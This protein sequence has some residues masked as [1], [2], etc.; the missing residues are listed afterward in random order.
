M[1]I[2]LEDNVSGGAVATSIHFYE[3]IPESQANAPEP[4]VLGPE[5]LEVGERYVMV[6]STSRRALSVQHRRCL[7]RLGLRG[8][9]SGDRVS[10]SNRGHVV[11]HRRKTDGS[12]RDR[13]G[14]RRRGSP[15]RSPSGLY[16][17]VP[18]GEGFPRYIL[19][20][21]LAGAPENTDDLA[22]FVR[23]FDDAL[24][25][26]NGEYRAKR[27]S[28]RLAAP[29]LW[30]VGAGSYDAHRRR[31]VA[32]GAHELQLKPTRL[33]RDSAFADQFEV[34]EKVRAD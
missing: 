27:A 24:G 8:K 18:A 34:A 13:G 19:L 6:L 25:R 3:F 23:D 31:R 17:A 10:L 20:A 15:G 16:T 21:E 14:I 30:I 29:E 33:S 1:A 2:P 9:N 4:D 26:Q 7:P 11:A 32:A 28:G 5:Q 12:S 22:P